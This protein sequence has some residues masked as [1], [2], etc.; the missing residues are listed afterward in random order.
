MTSIAPQLDEIASLPST[1]KA[2]AYTSLLDTILDDGNAQQQLFT[3]IEHVTA[4]DSSGI[5]LVVSKHVV[6]AFVSK[7]AASPPPSSGL[8]AATQDN[9]EFRQAIAEKTLEN[10]SQRQASFED[11][12]RRGGAR[13]LA[14]A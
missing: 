5:S 14:L 1:S 7:L 6:A 3:F 8:L 9:A 4:S 10:C 13:A 12:V 2:A 11:Q